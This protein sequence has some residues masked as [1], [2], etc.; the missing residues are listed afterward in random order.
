MQHSP[1]IS[2][3]SLPTQ[4]QDPRSIA[5]SAAVNMTLLVAALVLGH[6]AHQVAQK[7]YQY[8]ELVFPAD[9]P[10][11][12]PVIHPVHLAAPRDIPILKIEPSA[13]AVPIR[14]AERP[15]PRIVNFNMPTPVP[16]IEQPSVSAVRLAPQPKLTNAFDTAKATTASHANI[17]AVRFG[18]SLFNP[19]AANSAHVAPAGS[20]FGSIQGGEARGQVGRVA[21][22]GFGVNSANGSV[23]VQ[24][25]VKNV[26]LSAPD[27]KPAA[28]P[29]VATVRETQVIVTNKPVP[30]YTDEARKL[31]VQGR[32]VLEVTFAANGSVEVVRIIHGLGHGLDEQAE[33]AA[34]RIQFKPATKNGAPVPVTTE[35]DIQ[36]E[37]A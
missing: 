37:L 5:L 36:F 27:V 7:H 26:E 18:V 21:S 9:T 23:K 10:R 14:Q 13:I 31:R 15:A 34:K 1:S 6:M 17:A 30:Q 35:I 33:R 22:S 3:A 16:V 19:N 11:I 12:R 4:K 24:G 25:Q 8:M 32:V 28:A 29:V 2:F 20:A